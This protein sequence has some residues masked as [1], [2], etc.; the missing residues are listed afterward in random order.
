MKIL[1][2]MMSLVVSFAGFVCASEL[3]HDMKQEAS[4]IKRNAIDE[5][6]SGKTPEQVTKSAKNQ[7]KDASKKEADKMT[8]KAMNKALD[9][10]FK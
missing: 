5:A 7:A 10:A 2:V 3:K 6:S 8:D 1:L 9:K 4:S